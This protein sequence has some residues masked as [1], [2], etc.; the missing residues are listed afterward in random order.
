MDKPTLES[1]TSLITE[2]AETKGLLKKE[3]ATK[4]FL[5]LVEETGELAAGLARNDEDGIKDALGDIFV[6]WAIL[7][8]QLGYSHV[9]V[10]DAV[11]NIISKRTGKTVN[12]VFIKDSDL[13]K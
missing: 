13:S 4:Q 10:V 11:Y 5:K 7:V 8:E 6:V 2:W 3:N 1:L 12:G 9:D